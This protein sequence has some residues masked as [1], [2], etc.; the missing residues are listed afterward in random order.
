MPKNDQKIRSTFYLLWFLVGLCQAVFTDLMNDEVYYWACAQQLSWAYFDHTPVISVLIRFGAL[1]FGGSLGVRFGILLLSLL[2]LY[3]LEKLLKPTNLKLFYLLFSSVLVFQFGSFIAVPDV[4]LCFFTLVF[5]L[6]FDRFLY[7]RAWYWT[8]VLGL[9]M[10]ALVYAKYHGVVVILSAMIYRWQILR[11]PK[12]YLA[13]VFALLLFV[14]HL[15]WQYQHDFPSFWFQLVDRSSEPYSVLNSLEYIVEIPLI[16]GPL[17]GFI[18]LWALVKK[19]HFNSIEKTAMAVVVGTWIFFFI[20]SFK[21]RI[22]ANWIA[23]TVP[24]IFLLA[25]PEIESRVNWHKISKT[26]AWISI[27]L[28]ICLRVYVLD[29]PWPESVT[30]K[31]Q[32]H[33][34]QSWAHSI[35]KVA[36]SYPV[37]FTN[38]YAGA[39]KYMWYAGEKAHNI[40]NIRYRN[41]QFDFIPGWEEGLLGDTVI[42]VANWEI[43]EFYPLETKKGVNW[44]DTLPNFRAFSKFWFNT[45]QNSYELKASGRFT[46]PVDVEILLENPD[47]LWDAELPD[48]TIGYYYFKGTKLIDRNPYQ[49]VFSREILHE[50]KF[51]LHIEAPREPGNYILRISIEMPPMEAYVN[52]HKI[53]LK[54]E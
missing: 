5:C 50:K 52:S 7:Q 8:L 41:T 28:I 40:S 46:I 17:V 15:W 19:K 31:S 26:L 45:P 34:W 39:S 30:K 14:P 42:Y 38:S 29:L 20:S 12:F 4:P 13:A 9:C 1:F 21:D 27:G 18:F 24:L 48:P 3:F 23:H 49:L 36:G 6:V 25:Y 37:V 33:G 43:N 2:S 22:E 10:A 32:F 35:Q 53:Q 16:S 47:V 54:V 44:L 11:N 51:D